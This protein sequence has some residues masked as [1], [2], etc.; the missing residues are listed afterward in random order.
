MTIVKWLAV[1][2]QSVVFYF[3]SILISQSS[4]VEVVV[5]ATVVDSRE[6]PIADAQLRMRTIKNFAASEREVR[7]GGFAV[8]TMRKSECRT[9]AN[10]QWVSPPLPAGA[11]YVV[12]AKAPGFIGDFSRWVHP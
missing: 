1:W 2:D 4:A 10:G 5:A 12:E 7:K 3:L 8:V 9:D 11:G 6:V